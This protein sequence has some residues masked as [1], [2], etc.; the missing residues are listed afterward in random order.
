MTKNLENVKPV[1]EQGSNVF[2]LTNWD[3]PATTL[4]REAERQ[5]QRVSSYARMV[6]ALV[7]A[8][9]FSV[10]FQPSAPRTM[11]VAAFGALASY[12]LIGVISL[13]LTRSQLFRPW[14]T[15]ALMPFDTAVY[16]FVVLSV[17]NAVG[18]PPSQFDIAPAFLLIFVLIS[19]SGLTYRSASVLILVLQATIDWAGHR[20]R[21]TGRVAW[22]MVGSARPARS[23]YFARRWRQFNEIFARSSLRPY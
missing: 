23:I 9:G 20:F 17:S 16:V 18:V 14:F 22:E 2:K 11:T 19:L 4:L 21:R 13:L 7:F 6:M 8:M 12:F 1:Q 15:I 3:S 5:A 10:L